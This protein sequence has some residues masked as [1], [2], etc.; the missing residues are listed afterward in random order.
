MIKR[1]SE[2]GKSKYNIGEI[3]KFSG[4]SKKA[5]RYYDEK[6]ILT[7]DIRDEN[8]SYR[9]YSESQIL[10]SLAIREMRLRGFMLEEIKYM[11]ENDSLDDVSKI[12]DARICSI[13]NE[14]HNLEK[15]LL[16][17]KNSKKLI[18]TAMQLTNEFSVK[19]NNEII[20]YEVPRVKC[21]FSRYKS[22]IYAKEVFWDRFA[23]IYEILDRK[24]YT[25]NGAIIGIF[26][27]H[28]TRQFFFEEG[29][30]EVLLPIEEQI[31]DDENVK[32]YGG[33]LMVSLVHVGFYDE[34]LEKYVALIKWVEKNNYTII[35][36]P[37]EEYLV[38]FTHGATRDKYVTRIGF[39]VKKNNQ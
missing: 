33:F 31:S 2:R 38:E 14:I 22:R 20:L 11:L 18:L 34:L 21:V 13:E 23:D 27:E 25:A 1:K 30:L 37:T 9:V 28:Y 8:T 7:P 5:L 19:N 6:N 35:G 10:K 4:L 32:E 26:H 16:L 24:G 39:P 17:V 29:D 36:D 3:S 15:Q 12:L